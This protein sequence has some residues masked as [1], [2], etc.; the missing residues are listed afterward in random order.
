M[1]AASDPSTVEL[2][3]AQVTFGGFEWT[4][5]AVILTVPGLLLLVGVLTQAVVGVLFVPITRRSMAAD[6]RRRRRR[7]V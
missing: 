7:S 6:R 1:T 3:A 5:P 4:V 2:D